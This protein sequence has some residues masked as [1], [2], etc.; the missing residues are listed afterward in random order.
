MAV[1][2]AYD[3]ERD[4][5][6][7]DEEQP[8]VL[9]CFDRLLRMIQALALLGHLHPMG[10]DVNQCRLGVGLPHLVCKCEVLFC[11]APVCFGIHLYTSSLNY[12]FMTERFYK[13]T[14]AE[15][16]PPRTGL[17]AETRHTWKTPLQL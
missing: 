13:K 3:C 17:G 9:T 15:S 1:G 16:L 12:D 5:E 8:R 14:S 4:I 6:R 11:F 10:R 2:S 7:G